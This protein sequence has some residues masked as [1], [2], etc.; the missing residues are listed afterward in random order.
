MLPDV[1]KKEA[2]ILNNT[3]IKEATE[4]LEKNHSVNNYKICELEI[5]MSSSSDDFLQFSNTDK[6][7]KQIIQVL[8]TES[9]IM[10]NLLSK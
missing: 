8:E 6:I 9:P 4:P 1:D 5:V 3:S 7:K 2:F 10:R